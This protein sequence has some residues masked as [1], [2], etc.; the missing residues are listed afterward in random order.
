MLY[1]EL[2]GEL[3]V[4]IDDSDFTGRFDQQEILS[5]VGSYLM[6]VLN[7]SDRIESPAVISSVITDPENGKVSSMSVLFGV[8]DSD[9]ATAIERQRKLIEEHGNKDA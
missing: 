1:L 3:T 4:A 5:V 8:S 7:A 9:F 6:G 2:K